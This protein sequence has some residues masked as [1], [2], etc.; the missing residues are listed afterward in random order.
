MDRLCMK[1]LAEWKNAPHRKPL[2]LQGARQVGKTWIMKEFGKKYFSKVAYVNFDNNSRMKSLFSQDF[3]IKRIIM[4]INAETKIAVTP[5]DTLIIFDEVQEAPQ[6]IASL[7]YFCENAAEYPIIAAGSLLGVALH[8]GVSFPVG[9]VRFLRM[10]PLSFYEFLLAMGETGLAD[11]LSSNAYD[12]LPTFHER[13]IFWLKNYYYVGGMPEAVAAFAENNDYSLVRSI[14]RDLLTFY[15]LDFSKHIESRE[16]PQVRM[17][18]NAIPIQL[19]KE[20]KK[21]FFGRVKKGARSKDFAT[22]ISWL[23]DCGLITKVH[24]V[25]KPAMPLK[26]YREENAFKLF[27][28]DVGLLGALSGLDAGSLLEGNKTFVEFKGALTEQYVCQQL[29]ADTSYTPY[30]FSSDSNKYE[31][32]FLIQKAEYAVPLE[33]KAETNV[34]SKSLKAFR[35]KYQPH[36]SVRLSL[37]E[38]REQEQLLNLPLYAVHMLQLFPR[39]NN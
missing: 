33:V 34:H 35:E 29:C 26:A 38:F 12:L 18:W 15:E 2:L 9:K 16:L 19:A 6:A 36:I 7:K 10:Y 13:L 8:K 24:R 14:Q 28:L 32:D 1:Q 30:Y 23:A 39:K 31:I 22:A 37:N 21:F 5:Q 20:N 17:V 3:D 4:A 11:I 27:F 25:T